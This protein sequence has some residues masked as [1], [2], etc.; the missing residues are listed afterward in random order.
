M[1]AISIQTG[2]APV[3]GLSLYYEI[4]GDGGT[5][6]VLLHG[7]FGTTGMFTDLLPLLAAGRQVIAGD[8]QA[9]GR[10]ADIDRPLRHD[11]IAADIA[12]LLGYL[13]ISSADVLGYSF[14][15]GVALRTAIQYPALVRRL[16]VI[17]LPFALHGWYPEVIEQLAQINAAAAP[18]FAGS[19]PHAAYVAVAPQPDHFPLLLDKI[20]VLVRQPYDWSA[21]VASLSL[22]V[23]LVFGDADAVPPAH[24]A[25]FFEL[26]GGGKADPGWD[27][28]RMPAARL[29]IL[30]ATT[31]YNILESPLLVAVVT[32]FL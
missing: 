6:L 2:Y 25:A 29:A 23:L 4:H 21:D 27:G 26:L 19:P 3:N 13:E 24:A 17:S 14:G 1:T 9:H 32:S 8:L 12:A 31:H 20:G 10:T 11:L 15:A 7:A 18:L 22:P 30:P 5:P 16:V 28:A